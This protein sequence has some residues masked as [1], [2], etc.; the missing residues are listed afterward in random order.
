MS[1]SADRRA[2][3]AALPDRY[4]AYDE[5]TQPLARIAGY[6]ETFLRTPDN[7]PHARPATLSDITGPLHL[8]RKL[9]TGMNDLSR[10]RPDSPPAMGQL[11]WVTGRLLDEDGAAVRDSVIEVWHANAAGRYN[12]KMDAGS[13]FPLD[14][15]FVGS[16]RCVTD[17]EGRYAFLTIKP[18]AYPVPNHPTRWWRPPHIHLSVFGT[19]FMSRLVTQMF[20]PDDPLNAQDL[21]LHSVPDPAGRERLISQSIPMPELPRADLL[22]YR[23]DIVVRGHR[24]TPTGI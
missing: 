22:G 4:A 17:H 9:D 1:T 16:G 19:G 10:A 5:R 14:P 20:F 18:G 15:N 13:P 11:I 6:R 2:A 12:H 21:I 8:A 3:P 7:A 24:A 23:H